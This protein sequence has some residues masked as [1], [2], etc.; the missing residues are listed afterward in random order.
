MPHRIQIGGRI[1]HWI[2]GLGNSSSISL[3][4]SDVSH[5]VCQYRRGGT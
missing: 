4:A 3:L 2:C 5:Q 1:S